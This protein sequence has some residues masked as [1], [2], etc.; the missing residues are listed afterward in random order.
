DDEREV[1]NDGGVD[2]PPG[3]QERGRFVGHFT[4]V[5]RHDH[6]RSSPRST[7]TACPERSTR[8]P[9]QFTFTTPPRGEAWYA[10]KSALPSRLLQYGPRQQWADPVTGSSSMPEP[11]A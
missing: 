2:V 3:A 10:T 4:P 1:E 8:S 11:G 7:V 5:G 6:P 9:R